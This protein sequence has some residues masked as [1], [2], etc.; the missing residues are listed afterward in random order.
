MSTLESIEI[1]LDGGHTVAG[2]VTDKVFNRLMESLYM[3]GGGYVRVDEDG[4]E[5]TIIID[6]IV[7]VRMIATEEA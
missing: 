7:A 4:I 6:K 1:L 2:R 3:H 5:V